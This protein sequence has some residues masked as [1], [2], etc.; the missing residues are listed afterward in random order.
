MTTTDS[1]AGE[2]RK[3]QEQSGGVPGGDAEHPTDIPPK[4]WFQIAK[5]GWKEAKADQVPF[6]SAGVAYY[7]FLAL[8][9][10]LLA[11]VSLYGLVADPATIAAQV[12]A[13]AGGALP[14]DVQKLITDQINLVA[15]RRAALS[16]G[17]IVGV[18]IALFSASG[19]MANLMT[20]IS[21]AYDEE[22]K[23]GFLKKRLLALAL[24]LG[25]IVF[26]VIML[27]LIAVLPPLLE[28][29]LGGGAFRW[30]LQIA[31]Y[32]LMFVIVASAL[33]ILY[34]FAPDRDAPKMKW[35][36]VG[37][38]VATVIWLIASIGFSI[39]TSTLGNYAKTYGAI[40]GIVILLFWLWLTAYAILLGAEINAE[41]E[42]QTIRD[43]TRG[44]EEP[45]GSRDAV[46]ADSL[47]P[48]KPE[49]ADA[50]RDTGRDQSLG[51]KG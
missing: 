35:V 8:F 46:K 30:V 22:E 15:S 2:E 39:Y 43:T 4:G 1:R 10:A 45:L 40:A 13:L 32:L 3:A 47:P 31:G 51:K 24:T 7:A 17:V 12:D 5:R 20:A 25:A 11:L 16:F 27:A 33:A 29:L 49:M 44:P 23:R 21:L 42:Q 34:R 26:M 36:S 48:D 38:L 41:A 28:R 50:E 6:L 37:A 19:G 9:P 14:A 18:A